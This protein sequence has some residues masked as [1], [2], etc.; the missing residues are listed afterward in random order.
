MHRKISGLQTAQ[1]TVCPWPTGRS[2][3]GAKAQGLR[4]E[5][6]V[7]A[8]LPAD[9]EHNPWFTFIDANGRGNCAP[10]FLLPWG[11]ELVVLECK[12]TWVPEAHTQ[13]QLLY[14]PVVERALRRSVLTVVVCRH[15]TAAMPANLTICSSLSQAIACARAGEAPVWHNLAV[16]LRPRKRPRARRGAIA[17]AEAMAA[18]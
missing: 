4:Y 11:D 5:S 7:G 15:L 13:L 2:A 17:F 18:L 6:A 8:E 3:R 1:R 9:A 10:D 16:A 14:K 12:Y